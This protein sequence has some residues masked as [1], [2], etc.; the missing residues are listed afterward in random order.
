MLRV[1]QFSV[2]REE[3]KTRPLDMGTRVSGNVVLIPQRF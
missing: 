1:T 3:A 2:G